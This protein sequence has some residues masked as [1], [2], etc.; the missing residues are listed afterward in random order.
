MNNERLSI[1]PVLKVT[2]L[3]MPLMLGSAHPKHILQLWPVAV[4]KSFAG[5]A[6]DEAL[7]EHAKNMFIE[8][9]KWH[10]ADPALVRRLT[11]T[12]VS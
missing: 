12:P 1:P 5:L 8:R 6:S 10:F 9:F 11:T 3:G 4:I 2:S 7:A